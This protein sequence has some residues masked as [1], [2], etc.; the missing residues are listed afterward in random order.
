VFDDG[1]TTRLSDTR[2]HM[3]TTTVN[4]ARVYEWLEKH[5]QTQWRDLDVFLTAVT[6]DWAGIAIAGPQARAVLASAT[7]ADV[8]DAALP[9]M[10]VTEAEVAGIPARIFRISFSGELAYEVNVPAD[11]GLALWEALLEAGGPHGLVP[12]GLE[13]LSVLRI[14]KGHI[15]GAEFDGRATPMDLGFERMIARKKDFIGKWAL[16]RPA[17][18]QP[19]RLQL[20]GLAALDPK[21]PIPAAAQLV[22]SG[23]GQSPQQ[24]HGHV[25]SVCYSPNLGA[26]I[27]LGMLADGRDRHGQEIVA[28][29]PLKK[30]AVRV[31]VQPPCFVDPEGRRLH[32]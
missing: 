23:D 4:A 16:G 27:A 29:S 25:T 5:L 22:P 13:A 9:F 11:Q 26:E 3:T 21:E 17:F 15:V 24:S 6:D 1:V 18:H 8:S 30:R 2:F 10:G 20:V 32:G 31:R 7:R 12:Y 19:G 28:V 14:E